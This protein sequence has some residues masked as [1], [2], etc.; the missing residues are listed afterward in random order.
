MHVQMPMHFEQLC[1]PC[2]IPSP[3]EQHCVSKHNADALQQS[4]LE[5]EYWKKQDKPMHD[6]LTWKNTVSGLS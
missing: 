2:G 6:D 3:A 5:V 1:L 4:A